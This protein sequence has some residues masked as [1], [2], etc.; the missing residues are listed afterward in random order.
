MTAPTWW[1]YWLTC[2]SAYAP[3][4]EV[5]DT[6]PYGMALWWEAVRS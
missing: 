4:P 5:G 6:C 2:E 3:E 1:T